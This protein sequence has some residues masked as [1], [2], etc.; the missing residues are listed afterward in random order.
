MTAARRRAQTRHPASQWSA[1]VGRLRQLM[2]LKL[3]SEEHPWPE[4][5]ATLMAA[6]GRMGLDR[7][8]F[9]AALGI[10]E[11]VVEG[12]E[13]GTASAGDVER[14]TDGRVRPAARHGRLGIESAG[15][16]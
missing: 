5:A 2:V 11:E 4:M 7:A 15:E 16:P 1:D 13:D 3:R 6:R 9:A 14:W 8:E 12:L 10:A